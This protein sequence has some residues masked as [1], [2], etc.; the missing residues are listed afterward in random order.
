MKRK[1]SF[2]TIL[3][4]RSSTSFYD[5]T[6][7]PIPCS[8]SD[9]MA[10]DE[11]PQ[12]LHS[13]TRKRFKNDRPDEQAVYDNTLRWLFSAQKQ[14][15]NNDFYTETTTPSGDGL[16]NVEEDTSLEDDTMTALPKPDPSQRTLHHFFR[17]ASAPARVSSSG[18]DTTRLNTDTNSSLSMPAN[19]VSQTPSF[20][21]TWS[22]N[23]SLSPNPGPGTGTG[24]SE[25]VDMDREVQTFTASATAL[26][27]AYQ[28]RSW[29][30]G[31][32]FTH[33]A[34]CYYLLS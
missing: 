13:R 23:A 34:A 27:P 33:P 21:S 2:S 28:Q 26:T 24:E 9:A 29:M 1:A 10:I 5:R 12:H 32:D 18:S 16:D 30:D 31:K 22:G 6:V 17:P 25:D 14:A 19:M 3:S 4:P 8:L 11:T 7:S 15:E 20:A